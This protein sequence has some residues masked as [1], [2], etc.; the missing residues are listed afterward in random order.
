M[1]K[2]DKDTATHTIRG[3]VALFLNER[4]QVIA[5][6]VDFDNQGFG[7]FG[8]KRSQ[9]IRANN[10]LSRAVVAAYCSPDFERA[11]SS[12]QADDIVRTLVDT[13]KC[14]VRRIYVGHELTGEETYG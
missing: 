8:L 4:G 14:S 12:Y 7:G 9:E 3:V 2:S 10:R 11:V 13:H 5:E 1:P 6:A